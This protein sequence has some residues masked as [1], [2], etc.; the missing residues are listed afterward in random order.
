[1]A[2]V[3]EDILQAFYAKLAKSTSVDQAIVDEL[4][5]ALTTGKKLKSDDFVTILEK[6]PGE[7]KP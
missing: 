1:M 6:E 3:Q 7:V 2:T 4:R 5:V